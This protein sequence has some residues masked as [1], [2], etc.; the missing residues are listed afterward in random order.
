[1]TAYIT[2][3]VHGGCDLQKVLDW[4]EE[5]GQNLGPGDYL[6]VA[7]DFGYPWDYSAEETDEILWLESRPYTV[8][9]VDG[10]HERYDF[11]AERPYEDWHGGKVQRLRD[12]GRI[13]R[14][15]RGEVFDI[16]GAS[17]FTMGGATSVDRDFRVPYATWWPQE[18]PGEQNFAEAREALEANKW[19]VDYVVTHT[20]ADSMLRAALYPGKGWERPDRDRLTGFLEELEGR[21]SYKRW[22]FGHFHRDADLE[23]NHTVLY[24]RVV[25]LGKGVRG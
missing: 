11:W 16:C 6:I 4:D 5:V 2:G 19:Q 25:E 7:G 22:Y 13:R 14:L 15:C 8:L 24:D 20:C 21:L 18:Q 1:M 17:V 3:D 12:R 10:N 23:R 9:F